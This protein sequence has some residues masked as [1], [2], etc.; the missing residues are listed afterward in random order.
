MS[1]NRAA[2]K[3]GFIVSEIDATPGAEFVRFDSGLVLALGQEMGGVRDEIWQ[4]QI[5]KTVKKHLD[6]ELQGGRWG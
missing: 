4:S 6:K 2:Y 3:D 1:D 5:R